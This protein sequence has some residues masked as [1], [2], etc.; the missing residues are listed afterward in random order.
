MLKKVIKLNLNKIA[1]FFWEHIPLF[2]W[3]SPFIFRIFIIFE[4]CFPIFGLIILNR[5]LGSLRSKGRI[6]KYQLN[7]IRNKKLNY[8]I[9]IGIVLND[10]QVGLLLDDLTKL[11][12]RGLQNIRQ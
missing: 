8:K 3:L 11:L 4:R 2:I 1:P 7:I 12:I 10:Q 6:S 5:Q 9:E